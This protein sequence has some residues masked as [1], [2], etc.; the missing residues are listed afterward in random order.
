MPCI[1]ILYKN[2]QSFNLGLDNTVEFGVLNDSLL[3]LVSL[4]EYFQV[5]GNSSDHEL[6][7]QSTQ[8][9]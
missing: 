8:C 9:L 5:C 6:E 4:M 1:S 2:V 7:V 3:F